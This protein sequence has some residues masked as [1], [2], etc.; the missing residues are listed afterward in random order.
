M[1]LEKW[2]D[3]RNREVREW[4]CCGMVW[5]LIMSRLYPDRYNWK[6]I[7]PVCGRKI[8]EVAYGN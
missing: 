1:T 8:M 4:R 7:C 5:Q 6:P 2:K 3:H